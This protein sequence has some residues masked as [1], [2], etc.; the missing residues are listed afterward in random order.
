LELD[1]Q[2]YVLLSV[3][4]WVLCQSVSIAC[5]VSTSWRRS[6]AAA[7]VDASSWSRGR[8]GRDV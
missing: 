4:S 1:V 6:L 2:F 7:R 5:F 3:S 8:Q